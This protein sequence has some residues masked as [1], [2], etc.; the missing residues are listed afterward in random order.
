MPYIQRVEELLN[1]SRPSVREK[2]YFLDILLALANL[3][4]EQWED[5]M[6]YIQRLVPLG[7]SDIQKSYI[8]RAVANLAP[9]QLTERFIEIVMDLS[10]AE[11]K[12]YHRRYIIDYL[13]KVP[14]DKLE[15]FM[16]FMRSFTD[17]G[18]TPL[19]KRNLL[20]SLTGV[21]PEEWSDILA[22]IQSFDATLPGKKKASLVYTLSRM[23]I[24]RRAH[25]VSYAQK[26]MGTHM[27][28]CIPDIFGFLSLLPEDALT[29]KML[30]D[31][32]ILSPR[33]DQGCNRIQLLHLFNLFY[34]P[35]L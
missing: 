14:A 3:P 23:P 22:Y 4:M 19:D 5:F 35:L 27:T 24:Q 34:L 29:E 28:E 18:M 21:P 6:P 20:F 25:F 33:D 17:P 16:V 13:A 9:E 11:E 7:T 32:L 2:E 30:K 12:G 1:L 10:G 31:I 26:F 15:E 8:I